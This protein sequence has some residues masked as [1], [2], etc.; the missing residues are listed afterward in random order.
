MTTTRRHETIYKFTRLGNALSFTDRCPK[1]HMI[2]LGDD[3]RFWVVTPAHAARLVR[4]GY[5]L[6]E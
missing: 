1:I 6:A 4:Q 2:I 5:E 3:E